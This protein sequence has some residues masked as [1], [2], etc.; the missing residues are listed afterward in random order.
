MHG[1]L[2]NYI[3]NFVILIVNV[4]LLSGPWTNKQTL[5]FLIINKYLILKINKL[6]V[7][8]RKYCE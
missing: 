4:Y 3:Q 1:V 6:P 8:A 7:L 5:T 2:E